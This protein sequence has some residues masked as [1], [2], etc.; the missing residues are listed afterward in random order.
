MK[1][2]TPPGHAAIPFMSTH[3]EA[4][5]RPGAVRGGVAVVLRGEA[6]TVLVL[7]VV[8]YRLLGGGWALFAWLFLIPDLGMAGYLINRRVGAASYNLTHTYI[9]AAALAGFAL[10]RGWRLGELMALIWAAHIGFDRLLGY[11][12]KY[13]VG[14]KA[15]H[16]S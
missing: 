15:T 7:S 16:L 8:A 11:G 5:V 14:F 13:A 4:P 1:F 9:L 12:L 10:W 3:V 2:D 6:L